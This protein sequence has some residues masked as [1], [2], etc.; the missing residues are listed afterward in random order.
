M[1]CNTSF[2]FIQN[3][4]FWMLT[5]QD[6][7]IVNSASIYLLKVNNR[8]TSTRCKKCSKL[9]IKTPERHHC[10]WRCSGVF[11]VNFKHISHLVL[12]FFVN[13]EHV[14]AGLVYAT[15]SG[16]SQI[17]ITESFN[18]YCSPEGH[19]YFNKHT[20]K[21]CRFVFVYMTF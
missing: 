5:I 9:T 4:D 18:V 17:F 2:P 11:I 3:Q 7:T 12:V 10:R 13:F 1:R 21:S 8:N 6:S 20:A 16:T 19:T 15:F 14:I